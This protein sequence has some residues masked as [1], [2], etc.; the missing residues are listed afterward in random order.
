MKLEKAEKERE[1]EWADVIRGSQKKEK[2]GPKAKFLDG[3]WGKKTS[4]FYI[5]AKREDKT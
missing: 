3:E 5:L 1:R 4:E 2:I